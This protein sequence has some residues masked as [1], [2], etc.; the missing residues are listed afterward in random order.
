MGDRL[1]RLYHALPG[2]ARSLAATARGLYLRSW[3]YGPNTERLVHEALDRDSWSRTQWQAWQEERLAYVLHRAATKVPYFR[4]QWASRRRSGDRASWEILGNWPKL[5]KDIVRAQPRAFVADDCDP[6]RMFHER[7][8]GTTGKPLDLWWSRAT[9]Q[10]WYALFEARVRSWSG[11]SRR[12]RWAIVGGQLVVPAGRRRPPYWVWNAALS[13]LYVSSYH[14][15]P[16]FIPACLAALRRYG[17]TYLFGYSSSLHAMACEALA[18]GWSDQALRV[19]ITNAEP[20]QEHQ[21]KTIEQAF[22]C[23]VR[24]TYGMA[25]IVAAAAECDDGRLHVWPEVGVIEVMDGHDNVAPGAAGDFVCTGLINADMPLIRYEVGDAG[26]ISDGPERCSCGRTLPTIS[27]VD[28]RSGDLLL[29][30]DGRRVFWLNPVFYGLPIREAQIVQESLD[31]L[32][33]PFVP[34]NGFTAAHARSLIQRL[35]ARMG[36]VEVTLEVV[37]QIPRGSNRNF[38]P[39]ICTVPARERVSPAPA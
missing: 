24:Q 17:V 18:T 19:A 12:D 4:E 34:A 15:A 33:V 7:T 21:R 36:K 31:T 9:V 20:L 16:Q 13:Q 2:P 5:A 39:V 1:L 32:R 11:V 29:T 23:R 35:H 6:R 28:G 37:Q 38:R 27:N 14:M 30:R 10:A 26:G 25:E 8:S 3:R 22:N